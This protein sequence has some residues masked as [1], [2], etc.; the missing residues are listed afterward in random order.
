ML[1]ESIFS[2]NGNEH[3][4][5][6]NAPE[7]LMADISG[8]ATALVGPPYEEEDEQDGIVDTEMMQI[9]A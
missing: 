3:C 5:A 2:A 7:E 8:E 1:D 4:H 9:E 6:Q